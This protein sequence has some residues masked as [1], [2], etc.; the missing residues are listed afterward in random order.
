M[1]R[2]FAEA[3]TLLSET[4][5]GVIVRDGWAPYRRFTQ[6]IHQACLAHLLRRCRLLQA[7]HPQAT[8]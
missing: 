4:F 6:A 3:A 2:G 7:D 5:D 8:S 1:H